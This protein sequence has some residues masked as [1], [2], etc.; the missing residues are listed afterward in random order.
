MNNILLDEFEKSQYID[1]SKIKCD[2]CKEKSKYNTYNNEFYRCIEC[3]MD[4]CPLC[5]SLNDSSH[6]IIN[7]DQKNNI[8]E[9]HNDIYVKYCNTCKLNICWLC[10]KE[11]LEHDIISYGEMIYDD[12]EIKKYMNKLRETIDIF[13]KNIE[14]II[15]K[16]NKVKENIEIFYNINNDIIKNHDKRN[17]NYEILQNI[18]EIKNN[19]ILEELIKIN[20]DINIGNKIN[21]IINTY[22]LMYKKRISEINKIYYI[23]GK[24]DNIEIF[25]VEFVK[26]L[27]NDNR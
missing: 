5:K 10:E 14:E 19:N 24:E 11:H 16:L 23:N 1:I 20:K 7:Y 6:H 4:I 3:G 15:D 27:Q 26:N 18:K 9:K 8:C 17:R 25:G 2:I 13:K 21:N 22:N 12:N